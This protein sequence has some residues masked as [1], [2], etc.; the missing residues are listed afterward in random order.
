M[1][2]KLWPFSQGQIK[3]FSQS[4]LPSGDENHRMQFL[5]TSEK[6]KYLLIQTWDEFSGFFGHIP[7]AILIS[8]Y[9]LNVCTRHFASSSFIKCNTELFSLLLFPILR[10][11]WNV[12]LSFIQSIQLHLFLYEVMNICCHSI[13]H[14]WHWTCSIVKWIS[15]VLTLKNMCT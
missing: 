6:F 11:H 15:I 3:T 12:Y 9:A 8:K 1:Y 7:S 5:V 4:Q 14:Y 2:L 13:F 10:V